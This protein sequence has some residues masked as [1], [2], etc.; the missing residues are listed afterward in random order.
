MDIA[1]KSGY[2]SLYKMKLVSFS[3]ESSYCIKSSTQRIKINELVQR[4]NREGHKKLECIYGPHKADGTGFKTS[5]FWYKKVPLTSSEF[6]LLPGYPGWRNLGKTALDKCPSTGSQAER[7]RQANRNAWGRWGTRRAQS[8][9]N[10]S[11]L[12][13]KNF[14]LLV[15]I[16]ENPRLDRPSFSLHSR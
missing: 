5:Y 12:D 4:L 14:L 6:G 1:G 3:P 10:I 16:D 2:A 11:V 9:S 7:I 13:I 8:V 15:R